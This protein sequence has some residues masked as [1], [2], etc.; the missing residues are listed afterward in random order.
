MPPPCMQLRRAVLAKLE[1]ASC[2]RAIWREWHS[3]TF[4]GLRLS[5][6]IRLTGVAA[7]ARIRSFLQALPEADFE[8]PGYLVAD[9]LGCSEKPADRGVNARIDALLIEDGT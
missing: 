1:G 2:T 3:A 4:S 5:L 6:D 8:I 7:P 9:I